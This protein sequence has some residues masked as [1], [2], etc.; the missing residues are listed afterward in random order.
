MNLRPMFLAALLLSCDRR[1]Q[2]DMQRNTDGSCD[3]PLLECERSPEWLGIPLH[4]STC[5]LRLPSQPEPSDEGN[6]RER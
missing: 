2:L 3:S 1:G 4:D 6:E 5:Q